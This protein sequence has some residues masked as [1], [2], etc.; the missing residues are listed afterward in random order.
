MKLT[1][2]TRGPNRNACIRAWRHVLLLCVGAIVWT[3]CGDSE[4]KR[5]SCDAGLWHVVQTRQLCL[6]AEEVI[7]DEC[8]ELD[9]PVAAVEEFAAP[10]GFPEECAPLAA[11]GILTVDCRIEADLDSLAASID[12]ELAEQY[13]GDTDLTGCT[14]VFSLTGDG[15]YSET[16]FEY[17]ALTWM[18]CKGNCSADAFEI[19]LLLQLTVGSQICPSRHVLT[20][21]LH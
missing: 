11:D 18:R 12:P 19:C 17:H 4:E 20:G 10:E 21:E 8:R 15:T 2:E 14:G 6:Q 9:D 3:A 7:V 1:A 16:A 13:L 5:F